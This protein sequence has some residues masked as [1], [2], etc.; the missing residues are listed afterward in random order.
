MVA[1]ADPKTSHTAGHESFGDKTC[2]FQTMSHV[3]AI[4]VFT[5]FFLQAHEPHGAIQ[6]WEI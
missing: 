2:V 5:H 6:V 4:E 1:L 3:V